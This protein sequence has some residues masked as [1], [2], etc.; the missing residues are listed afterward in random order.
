[1]RADPGVDW[2]SRR[3]HFVGIGGAGMSGLAL[4]AQA[5]GASVSGSDRA[6]TGYLARLREHGI[7]PRIGHD[8]SNVP[9]GAEVVY[10]TAIPADNPERRAAGG[11]ELHRADLLAQIAS[12]KRC[13]AVTGTAG[14]TTTSA[15]LVRAL[16][17]A[18]LDPAYAV[19]GELRDT[20]SN[21]GWGGGEWIVVEADESDRSLLKLDPEIAVLTNADLDHHTTYA[22]RLDL[23]ATFREF[24]SRAGERAVVWDRPALR[25]LCPPDAIPYDAADAILSPAGSHFHWRGLEVVLSV[26]GGHNAINAAGA[27]TAAALAGADPAA[28]AASLRDFRGARRRFERL[29]ETRGGAVVYDDYAHHPTKVAAAVATGRSLDPRRLVAVFQPHLYSRTRALAREFGVALASA[30]VIV[31]LPVYAARERTED[32]P[33]VDG[34]L[35]AAAAADAAPGRTVGWLPSFDDARRFLAAN[36][37]DGDLCLLMGAGDIDALGRSLVD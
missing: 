8:A 35:V 13:L 1:M 32:Y 20:G 33:G 18:G 30:D 14:K 34:R 29:G 36:L 12:V 28:A 5:L 25:A 26:P 2:S 31:V 27:L 4:I 11:G 15:M 9:A 22:S 37:R 24:M 19:G 21:A 17:A 7:E 6:E 23:E 16:R 3:L 10:S